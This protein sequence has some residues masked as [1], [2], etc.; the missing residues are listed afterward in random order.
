[1]LKKC[2][3]ACNVPGPDQVCSDGYCYKTDA[4]CPTGTTT[5]NANKCAC[6]TTNNTMCNCTTSHSSMQVNALFPNGCIN[7]DNH[8]R[9]NSIRILL[10]LKSV[11]HQ[12]PPVNR[13]PIKYVVM[14]NV[15][16]VGFRA[17]IYWWAI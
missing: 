5:V 12:N 14:A 17:L 13:D 11:L 15:I 4:K 10:I 6:C 3:P 8:S 16:P 2:R 9:N 7:I 1:M